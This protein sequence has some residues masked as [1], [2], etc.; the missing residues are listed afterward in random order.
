MWKRVNYCWKKNSKCLTRHWFHAV[1]G[2]SSAFLDA[3]LVSSKD[4]GHGDSE[5]GD[6]DH[7]AT[8]RGHS[9]G[10]NWLSYNSIKVACIFS[11][12]LCDFLTLT[13]LF[14]RCCQCL[15]E[16]AYMLMLYWHSSFSLATHGLY[17]LFEKKTI[18]RF[19]MTNNTGQTF[20]VFAFGVMSLNICVCLFLHIAF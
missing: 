8:N 4:S 5:Q 10:K 18:N 6:S 13:L 7:D 14:F 2:C 12:S 1:F 11:V 15:Y 16:S 17:I 3:D 9:S 19:G 20:W